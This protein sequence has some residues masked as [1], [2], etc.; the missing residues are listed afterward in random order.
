MTTAPSVTFV[1]CV[2]SGGL[3]LQT[4]RFAESLRRWGGSFKDARMIA[5][6]PRVGPLPARATLARF[7]QLGVDY[8]YKPLAAKRYAWF[9]FG[10]KPLALTIAEELATTDTI[11]WADSD[12]LI[13]DQPD[14][15]L[16]KDEDFVACCSD[17]EMGSSGPGD[18]FEPLWQANCAALGIDIDALPWL[19]TEVDH[20]RVRFYWNG[21]LFAYRRS[22]GFARRFLD[23]CQR[24]MDARNT[25]RH[26]HYTV[27]INEMSAIG[28]SVVQGGL[29]WRG[30]PLSHNFFAGTRKWADDR[31][32]VLSQVKILHHHDSM[33]PHG[34]ERFV[35]RLA[36]VHPE[37][38]AWLRSEG[39]LYNPASPVARVVSRG[40][41]E[42]YT[43]AEKAY[44]ARCTPV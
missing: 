38:A 7:G 18:T 29:R 1:C 28:F 5:V 10:N 4:I 23:T 44:R 41:R 32:D 12:L 13:L 24:L 15:L 36:P 8:H 16:L 30:L 14:G 37:V 20:H 22:T 17:K 9:K 31:A 21:G 26:P 19:T 6:T 43:L 42:A 25:S 34:F 40:L 3:E 39:P 27:G 11:C 35:D 2:E 33:W